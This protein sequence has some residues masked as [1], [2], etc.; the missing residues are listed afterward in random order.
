MSDA[1]CRHRDGRTCSLGFGGQRAMPSDGYCLANHCGW[2]EQI[3]IDGVS[4]RPPKRS[5]P[6]ARARKVID[7]LAAFATAGR[8]SDAI[9]IE[10]E[11][12]CA[13]C[14]KSA[15]DERGI[16]CTVCGC[17]T[18]D[19]SR[20]VFNLAAYEENIKGREGYRQ[21][22]PQWGCRHPQRS[23]GKGWRR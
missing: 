21:S 3:T 4:L 18:S 20:R 14:D 9:R 10:R 12:T 1:I 23:K 8:V 6:R 2:L 15:E 17:G 19:E 16:W 22:L 11:A 7:W 5:R 13:S